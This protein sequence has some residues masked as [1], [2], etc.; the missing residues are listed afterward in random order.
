MVGVFE[1]AGFVGAVGEVFVH[2]PGFALV[3]AVSLS[4]V[5]VSMIY[6]PL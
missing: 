2:G 1:D 3:D 4:K 5:D 6:Q